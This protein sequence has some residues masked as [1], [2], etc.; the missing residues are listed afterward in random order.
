[1]DKV[2]VVVDGQGGG[3]GGRLVERLKPA[4]PNGTKIVALGTNALATAQMMKAG[5]DH[6]ASGENA[7]SYSAA[8]ASVIV[9]SLA[10]VMPNSMLGELTTKMAEAILRSS[11][12]KLLLPVNNEGLRVI[13]VSKDPLAI[14]I[15][16]LCKEAV[17]SVS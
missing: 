17:K 12:I 11:A 16:A 3:L 10:I 2:V 9:G 5:A 6:G 4:L 8:S 15:D 14:L 13:G 1:M 7:I